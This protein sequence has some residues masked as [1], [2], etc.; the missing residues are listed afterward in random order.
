MGTPGQESE[1]PRALPQRT[2]DAYL[3]RIG[4][5]RPARADAAALR[6]LQLR[7]LHTVPFENL[8]IHRGEN[9]VLAD[10]PLVAKIVEA[11]RG[12]F[13]YELNGAFAA[14]LR[15]LGFTVTLYQARVFG[16]GGR[17]G[18]PYDHLTLRVETVDGTGPWLA[19][20]GFGDHSHHPLALDDREDQQ[21][22]AGVFRIVDGGRYG[23]LDLL[24]GGK[25]QFRV[26][27]R[28]RELADFEAGAWYHR[29]SPA[30][31]FTQS[32]VCSRLTPEGRVT[33]S[34]RKLVVT[35]HGER[36]ERQLSDDAAVLAAYQEQF[37]L[38]L[39]RLPPDPAAR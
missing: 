26:D 25:P 3:R 35:E 5:D 28:P 11:R 36:H 17:L 32:L 6:E 14:L 16:Q 1:P 31:H 2:V 29:T 27:T 18:I 15:A 21:D 23:D 7:H 38:V 37:G 34:G 22:P 30:S 12:G 39:D 19:D 13:C 24:R 8:S 20:V 9:L 10:E 33:L 4:A